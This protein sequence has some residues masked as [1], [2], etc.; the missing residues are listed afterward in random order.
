MQRTKCQM[1]RVIQVLELIRA[2]RPHADEYASL[3][4]VGG[5]RRYHNCTT[6][7]AKLDVSSKTIIRDIEFLRDQLGVPIEYS[8]EGNGYYLTEKGYSFSFGVASEKR[9]DGLLKAE[10][11]LAG[12]GLRDLAED[13]RAVVDQAFPTSEKDIAHRRSSI[14]EVVASSFKPPYSV[15]LWKVCEPSMNS[16]CVARSSPHREED[17]QQRIVQGL[18]SLDVAA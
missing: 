15:D 3:S 18:A 6:M 9:L 7:A 17:K 2:G 11:I 16:Y 1:R 13:V 4:S 8:A 12:L 5:Y 14:G 10:A